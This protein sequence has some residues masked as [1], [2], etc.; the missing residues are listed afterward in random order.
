MAVL[1]GTCMSSEGRM[2]D[3][4][5]SLSGFFQVVLYGTTRFRTAKPGT[6]G[7]DVCLSWFS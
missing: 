6:S 4:R 1:A 2:R 7:T 3:C 5:G